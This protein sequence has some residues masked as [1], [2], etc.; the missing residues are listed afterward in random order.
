MVAIASVVISAGALATTWMS[1]PWQPC[2]CGRGRRFGAGCMAAVPAAATIAT[3]WFSARRSSVTGCLTAASASGRFALQAGAVPLG[4]SAGWRCVGDH[5]PVRAGRCPLV[6]L[7][8]R[9]RPEDLG[10]VTVAGAAE[11]DPVPAELVGNL[12]CR[13]SALRDAWTTGAFCCWWAASGLRPLNQ[14]V[15]PD[16][17]H[18]RGP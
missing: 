2:C 10:L 4:R 3:R 11:E 17:L 12:G 9:E 6:P 16:A 15:D 8:L 1:S 7:F 14:R 18:H 13:P 5:R